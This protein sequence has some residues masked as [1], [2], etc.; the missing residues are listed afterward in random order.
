MIISS[1]ELN[2]SW[3]HLEME[4]G[5][6]D[7]SSRNGRTM[8]GSL[9]IM[10]T[11]WPREAVNYLLFVT[12]CFCLWLTHQCKCKRFPCSVSIWFVMGEMLKLLISKLLPMLV[13]GAKKALIWS[14][15][16]PLSGRWCLALCKASVVVRGR[17]QYRVTSLDLENWEIQLPLQRGFLGEIAVFAVVCSLTRNFP[18]LVLIPCKWL[19]WGICYV[20]VLLH[21]VFLSFSVLYRCWA[22]KFLNVKPF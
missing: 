6:K 9:C 8:K 7:V 3:W 10:V 4:R 16:S 15:L 18:Q 13:S 2:T 22:C 21:L 17:I 14:F 20:L 1:S 11:T 5:W 19:V 12:T